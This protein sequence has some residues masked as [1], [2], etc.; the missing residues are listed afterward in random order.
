VQERDGKKLSSKKSGDALRCPYTYEMSSDSRRD[1]LHSYFQQKAA[2][3]Q[4][5]AA[6]FGENRRVLSL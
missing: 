1:S 6:A 2:V 3:E 5:F 4:P